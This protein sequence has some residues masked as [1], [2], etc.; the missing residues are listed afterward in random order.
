MWVKTQSGKLVNLDMTQS[1][2][3]VSTHDL[4][5][6]VREGDEDERWELCAFYLHETSDFLPQ[7][8]WTVLG[9][10]PTKEAAEQALADLDR[11]RIEAYPVPTKINRLSPQGHGAT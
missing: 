7:E 10:F 4:A 2:Q 5:G 1:I 11:F 9:T 3:V 6:V 8:E